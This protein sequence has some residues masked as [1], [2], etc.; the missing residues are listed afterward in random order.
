MRQNRTKFFG[1]K[2]PLE[3][4]THKQL[5]RIQNQAMPELI[6]NKKQ[7]NMQSRFTHLLE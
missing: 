1:P 2:Y 7:I 3:A 5:L 4:V 6:E